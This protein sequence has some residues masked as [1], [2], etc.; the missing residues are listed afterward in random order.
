MSLGY[1]HGAN[2]VDAFGNAWRLTLF[3]PARPE[4]GWAPG[5]A[6][7]AGRPN[8]ATMGASKVRTPVAC[9]VVAP[10]TR[11]RTGSIGLRRNLLLLPRLLLLPPRGRRQ[12]AALPVPVYQA[13]GV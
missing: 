12:R 8:G 2:Y 10:L 11:A 1:G 5:F 3:R 13:R 9:V 7:A 6:A 4:G